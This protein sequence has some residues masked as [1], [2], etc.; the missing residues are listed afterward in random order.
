MVDAQSGENVKTRELA[1]GTLYLSLQNLIAYATP[2]LYYFLLSRLLAPDAVGALSVLTFVLA[3]STILVQLALPTAATKFIAEYRGAGRSTAAGSIA[4]TAI[5][6]SAIIT[7]VFAIGSA[8]VAAPL[9]QFLFGSDAY[10]PLLHL[11][12]VAA[13]VLNFAVLFGAF[14]HGLSLFAATAV[15]TTVNVVAPRLCA[16]LFAGFGYGLNGILYGQVTG[17]VLSLACALVIV[18]GRFNFQIGYERLAARTMLVYSLPI[19]VIQATN[20]LQ[21]RIDSMIL[22][23]MTGQLDLTG[24][25]YLVTASTTAL[26]VLWIPISL[27]LFPTLSAQN[28]KGEFDRA[29]STMRTTTRLFNITVIPLSAALAAASR[30]AISIAYGP[31]YLAGQTSFALLCVVAI[32]AAYV[33]LFTMT[34]TAIAKTRTLLAIGMVAV[35]VD[36]TVTA[37]L[38]QPLGIVGAAVARVAM[39]IAILVLSYRALRQHL[40][41][42]IDG[43]SLRKSIVNAVAIA[44]PILLFETVIAD[45]LALPLVARALVDGALLV[46][47]GLLALKASKVLRVDD[48]DLLRHAL[49]RILHPLLR[50]A[51]RLLR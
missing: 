45:R 15:L 31:T 3:F 23:A 19:F 2:F 29:G 37:I 40:V 5:R 1:R 27:V 20:L 17:T 10:T 28:G 41:L 22:Y 21:S 47:F 32:L 49:P 33:S 35:G 46:S 38:A 36:V 42:R 48:F 18:R 14:L 44:V 24:I 12:F 7:V 13:S 30:T 34:L 16:I 26:S 50:I 4:R 8:V 9:A 11:V 51:E 6:T 25:Y 43:A 39:L